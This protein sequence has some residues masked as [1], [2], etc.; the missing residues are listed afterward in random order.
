M[1]RRRQIEKQVEEI[2][3]DKE[4]VIDRA[5]WCNAFYNIAKYEKWIQPLNGN[6][7]RFLKLDL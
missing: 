3:L 4:D 6:I 1:M 7:T 5:K 2:G